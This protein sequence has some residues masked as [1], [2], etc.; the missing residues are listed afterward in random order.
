MILQN[1][2]LTDRIAEYR[3]GHKSTPVISTLMIGITAYKSPY[4]ELFQYAF[5]PDFPAFGLNISPYSVRM[6]E[7]PGKMRTRIT[8]NTP[9]LSVFSPNAV[10]SGKNAD[11][12]NFQYVTFFTQCMVLQS[13][14][15]LFA[16]D[17]V[18][19]TSGSSQEETEHKSNKDILSSMIIFKKTTLS[20]Y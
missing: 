14:T 3:K 7:N 4:S 17:S 6:W 12:N 16:D 20:Q 1:Q 19:Y 2:N 8:P 15:I 5:F 18:L 10:K 9:Y 11:Q 13:E